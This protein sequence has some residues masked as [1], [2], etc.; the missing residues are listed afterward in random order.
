MD[1]FH[2][3]TTWDTTWDVLGPGGS[4]RA[5]RGSASRNGLRA[6]WMAFR[7]ELG[8]LGLSWLDQKTEGRTEGSVTGVF[9]RY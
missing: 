9:N 6:G 5:M 3:L 4:P 2:G 7:R 8:L 1:D